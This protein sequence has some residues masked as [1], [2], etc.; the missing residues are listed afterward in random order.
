MSYEELVEKFAAKYGIKDLAAE[1]GVAAMV[2]DDVK[3]EL[4]D[5]EEAG[6]SPTGSAR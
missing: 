2:I 4:I 6:C 3:V 1:N 5:D